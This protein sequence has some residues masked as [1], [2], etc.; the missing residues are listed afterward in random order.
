MNP[1]GRFVVRVS[2]ECGFAVEKYE[3]YLPRG[4]YTA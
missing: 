1:A 4:N 3:Q 2:L